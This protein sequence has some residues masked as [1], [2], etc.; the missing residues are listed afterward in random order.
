MGGSS[1]ASCCLMRKCRRQKSGE[2]CG[3]ADNCPPAS[4]G[5][6]TADHPSG[7]SPVNPPK[8]RREREKTINHLSIFLNQR[9]R[10]ITDDFIKQTLQLTGSNRLGP[11]RPENDRW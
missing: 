7:F 10:M 5:R 8:K 11:D 2:R 4:P 1:S 6:D 3:S 9:Q